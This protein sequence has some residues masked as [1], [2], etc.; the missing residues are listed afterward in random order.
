MTSVK[1]TQRKYVQK[2]YRVRNWREYETGLRA[3]GSLTV[4]LGLTD[5][6]LANWN[7]PRPTRRKPG[8]QRQYSNHVIET[9]VTLG[10]VFGLASRQTEGFLRSLRIPD[11]LEH[12]FRAKVNT[13]SGQ[14]EHRFRE[15]EHRFRPS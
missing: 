2:A 10:L 13:H 7:S 1:R 11:D 4:W 8:R 9:T 15:G 5:G 12:R 3:R 14:V 6:K